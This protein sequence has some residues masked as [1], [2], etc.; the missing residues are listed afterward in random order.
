MGQDPPAATQAAKG[1]S[2]TLNVAVD[3]IVPDV[4]AK[5]VADARAALERDG[6]RIGNTAYTQEGREGTVVRTEPGARSPEHAGA[7]ITLYVS[8]VSNDEEP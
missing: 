7:T 8:G 6:Y 5:P 1:T 3:G 2:V 4:T